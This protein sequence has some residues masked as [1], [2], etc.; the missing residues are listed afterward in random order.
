M[1]NYTFITDTGKSDTTYKFPG[2]FSPFMKLWFYYSGTLMPSAAI[3]EHD[4]R[5][6]KLNAKHQPLI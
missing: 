2:E 3:K 6:C 5:Y 1:G 4:E